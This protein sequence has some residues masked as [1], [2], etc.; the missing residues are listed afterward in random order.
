MF[1]LCRSALRFSLC[2][3]A[4]WRRPQVYPKAGN[5]GFSRAPTKPMGLVGST[6]IP[7][8]LSSPVAQ[9]RLPSVLPGD[10]PLAGICCLPKQALDHKPVCGVC[11]SA[12]A[13]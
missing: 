9:L 4:V 11:C 12:F 2:V 3:L 10:S 13:V 1:L 7:V 6:Q 5:S 8:E